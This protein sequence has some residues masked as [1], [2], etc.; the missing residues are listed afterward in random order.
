MCSLQPLNC[1]TFFVVV[2]LC[3]HAEDTNT[4]LP[5]QGLATNLFGE[6]T[7]K[8]DSSLLHEGL[9][10]NT[11]LFGDA[12][13]KSDSKTKKKNS[14]KSKKRKRSKNQL[15]IE[16][17]ELTIT[18]PDQSFT[19]VEQRVVDIKGKI[20]PYASGIVKAVGFGVITTSTTI[21][22][23]GLFSL[24]NVYLPEGETDVL[25]SAVAD[26][27]SAIGKARTLRFSYTRPYEGSS[28]VTSQDGG[29]VEIM[30]QD[31]PVAG[32]K[33]EVPPGSAKRDVRI[34][35][36]YDPEHVPLV[37]FR[38][39]AVGPPVRFGPEAETFNGFVSLSIPINPVL[40]PD[41]LD[42]TYAKVLSLTE[43]G[44]KELVNQASVSAEN[45]LTF[46]VNS[47]DSMAFVSVVDVP[48]QF[49]QVIIE[50]HPAAARLYV[51]GVA[52]G[53]SPAVVHALSS[54]EHTARIY[55]P[56]YNELYFSFET[57]PQG[58]GVVINKVLEYA[59]EPQPNVL[60]EGNLD[61]LKTSSS[62]VE[63]VADV[64]FEDNK[65]DEGIGILSINGKETIQTVNDG[66]IKGF[67][68]LDEG[69]N[70][71]EVRVI[72]PNGNTGVSRPAII[73]RETPQVSRRFLRLGE[74]T[75]RH[76][77]LN[78]NNEIKIVLSWNTVYTGEYL[79][80]DHLI[81]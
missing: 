32:A 68:S 10:T 51:D 59:T 17:H 48:L 77:E 61:G 20:T 78:A 76:L 1:T 5:D 15:P 67:V 16:Q 60:L 69:Y 36:L 37:P 53:T 38:Y 74:T 26:D 39:V 62:F 12:T 22:S 6:A 75:R 55:L 52:S 81:S 64:T 72:G 47:L 44:W 35:V 11:N 30:D 65:L 79:F 4:E 14:T 43:D 45:R 46:D 73:T 13:D 34:Q 63:I 21:L 33:F 80:A 57:P 24:E 71:V 25:V 28:F 9:A 70:H 49:D 27:G 3:V 8:S 23:S 50:T 41:S 2:V 31:S 54:G 66:Q 56:G 40:I 42:S 18:T 19:I 58:Q 7:D 29:G